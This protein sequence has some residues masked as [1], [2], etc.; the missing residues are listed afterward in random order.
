VTIA[1]KELDIEWDVL[2]FFVGFEIRE[3][4]VGEFCI[5]PN[6][7]GGCLVRAPRQSVFS[8]N[9][10]LGISLDLSG[11]LVSEVSATIE[12]IE[13]YSVKPGPVAGMTTGT[14][15]TP[16]CPTI[17]SCISTRCRSTS[18]S[19]TSPISSAISRRTRSGRSAACALA[20]LAPGPAAGSAHAFL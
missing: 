9:P 3:T 6:P 1:L 10:D 18:T 20:V 14:R 16:A 19:S 5:I 11:L 4:C 7:F 17:G 12:P 15:T 8:A 2:H 13:K